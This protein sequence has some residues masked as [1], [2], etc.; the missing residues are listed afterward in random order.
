MVAPG[1]PTLVAI[2]LIMIVRCRSALSSSL[3]A[4]PNILVLFADDLGY[5]DLSSFGHPT[6]VTPHL[7]SLARDGI[8][9]TAWY[10]AFHVCSPSRGSM[11]TGRLP[12]RL[13]LAGASWTGG[14]FNA[15]A[16]GG[17]PKNETTIAAALKHAGY[18]S[19][20]V[21]KW[22]LGQ[23]PEFLP[24][25]HGFDEYYGIPYSVDMGTSAWRTGLDHDRPYLPLIRSAAPGHMDVLEQPVDLNTL[26]GK[27]V[28]ESAAFIE[29]QSEQDTPWFL[30]VAFNHMHVPDFVSPAYCNTTRRGVFGDAL[31]E[32]DDA[33]GGILSAVDAAG[34]AADTIVFFTSDN[35]PWLRFR[36][37]GGSAGLLRDGKTTTWEG[38]IRVPGIA[39]WTGKIPAGRVERSPVATYDIY[40]TALAL[41]GV[42]SHLVNGDRIVDG[43]D[44]S[45]VLFAAEGNDRAGLH[46][47]DLHRCLFHYKGTPGLGC[48]LEHPGCPGL[49]A[50]RCGH[51]KMHYVT[52]DYRNESV[53]TFHD[54]PLMF[55]VDPDPGESFPLDPADPVYKAAREEMD[56]RVAAHKRSL[57][58]VPNQ[59]AMGNDPKLAVCCDRRRAC[60]CNPEN[61]RVFVCDGDDQFDDGGVMP[62]LGPGA[63]AGAAG[64]EL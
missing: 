12:I 31:R 26:S 56:G 24:T 40:A 35:G 23:R 41:A 43:V 9:F 64:A 17:L 42:D 54:P 61:M 50:V 55:H 7:D 20:A 6:T 5:G 2:A 49:W 21:G 34:A 37:A 62:T 46:T 11:M 52:T 30:Y 60:N 57:R 18:A 15:D 44:L 53:Q 39:R 63:R 28:N 3:P 16:I 48:P 22:H 47:K 51:F 1:R 32:L 36:E 10:S 58:K 38:G 4:R 14:V 45:P 13:G 29:A 33:V 19:K 59:I 25:S 27:Y 8:K